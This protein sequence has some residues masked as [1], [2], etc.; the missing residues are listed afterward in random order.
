MADV[1]NQLARM[2]ITEEALIQVDMKN[3]LGDFQDSYKKLD[4]FK[5]ARTDHEKRWLFAKLWHHGEVGEAQL[6]ALEVQ[7]DFSKTIGQ[8]MMISILQSKKLSEQQTLLNAQQIGLKTQADGIEKNTLTLQDQQKELKEQAEKLER[9]VKDYFALEGLTKNG[10]ERLVEFAKKIRGTEEDLQREFTARVAE[11]NATFG[12]FSLEIDDRIGKVQER[13]SQS[14]ERNAKHFE[15]VESEAQA[16]KNNFSSALLKEGEAVRLELCQAMA[17]HQSAFESLEGTVRGLEAETAEHEARTNDLEG[18][19]AIQRT[20][21]EALLL[22]LDEGSAQ[23]E[24]CQQ[25]MLTHGEAI[26]L[27]ER[28]AKGRFRKL[29]WTVGIGFVALFA[30][31]AWVTFHLRAL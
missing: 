31:V 27:V 15:R 21:M 4:N 8:L 6:D 16:I 2:E 14:D 13:V 18:S 30:M 1:I 20:G 29:G 3:V 7:A 11:M 23:V 22:K 12:R 24:A 9:L 10:A 19:A 25:L 28:H 26:S 5:K 17:T